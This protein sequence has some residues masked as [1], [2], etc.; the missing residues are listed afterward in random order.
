[1]TNDDIARGVLDAVSYVVLA[2]ADADGVPWASPVWFAHDEYRELYW[3]SA[4]DARHS[5]NIDARPRI[6][7]VVFDSTVAPN[8]GQAVY[9]TATASQ[10]RDPAAIDRGLAVF[11]RASVR[12]GMDPW[13]ADRVSGDARLRL[14]RA[15]VLEHSILDPDAAI[16][17]RVNVSPNS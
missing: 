14:Y 1:M 17:V 7:L 8:T 3:V 2:T 13:D 16:D 15:T 5:Q 10:V 6:S 11:S 12:A 4:P 9:M